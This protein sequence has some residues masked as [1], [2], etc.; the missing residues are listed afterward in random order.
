MYSFKDLCSNTLPAGNY[1]CQITEVKMKPTG[2][3]ASHFNLEVHY[4]VAEGT[5]A[6]RTFIDTIYEKASF[7]LKPFLTAIGTD[8]AR[9]F[10]SLEALYDYGCKAATG[11]TVM[12]E[13]GTRTYNGNTYNDVKSWSAMP[14]STTT[15]EDVMAEFDTAP[16]VAAEPGVTAAAADAVFDLNDSPLADITDDDLPF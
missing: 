16:T 7:R 2:D 1:K 11:K 9:E 12:V 6:K 8:M 13:L 5:Y 10:D 3:G 4:T 14:S 15:T